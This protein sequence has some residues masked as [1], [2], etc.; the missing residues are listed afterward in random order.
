M[1]ED[2][3]RLRARR[4]AALHARRHHPHGVPGSL[5]SP[6]NST[7]SMDSNTSSVILG[8]GTGVGLRDVLPLKS[9]FFDWCCEYFTEPQMRVRV[10]SRLPS[11]CLLFFF[12]A[13]QAEADEPGSIQYNY[14]VWRQQRNEQVI[15]ETQLQAEVARKYWQSA[16]LAMAYFLCRGSPMG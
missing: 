14:Q 4:K 9:T 16:S 5:P 11:S 13:Q 2:M 3:E 7:F 10:L 6:S 1:E 12:L 15:Q 8:L